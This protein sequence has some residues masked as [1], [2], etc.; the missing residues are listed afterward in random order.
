MVFFTE[1]HDAI[2]IVG[3]LD[4]AIVLRGLRYHPIDIENSVMQC[5]RKISEW[6]V[7]WLLAHSFR[8]LNFSNLCGQANNL[9]LSSQNDQC[10]ALLVVKINCL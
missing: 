1:R 10:L 8:T 9:L 2:F 4:E 5:H 6:L 3:A 7:F